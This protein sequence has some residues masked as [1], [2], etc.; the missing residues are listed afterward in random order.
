MPATYATAGL[1]LTAGVM[2]VLADWRLAL[3][4]LA[5]QYLLVGALLSQELLAQV[6]VVKVLVGGVVSM[7]SRR[8]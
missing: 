6:A 4:A 2:L 8:R 7:V 1:I 3:L 5:V